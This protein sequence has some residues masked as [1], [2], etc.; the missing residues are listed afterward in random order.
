MLEGKIPESFL[1]KTRNDHFS[2]PVRVFLSSLFS[3]FFATES[4]NFSRLSFPI[5]KPLFIITHTW[6]CIIITHRIFCNIFWTFLPK[7]KLAFFA[8]WLQLRQSATGGWSRENSRHKIG[9]E[10]WREHDV[11]KVWASNNRNATSYRRLRFDETSFFCVF[12]HWKIESPRNT[13]SSLARRKDETIFLFPIKCLFSFSDVLR[14][15]L[16]S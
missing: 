10:R 1:H 5:I 3:S 12:R 6:L 13:F 2:P 4:A 16:F 11:K 8:G 15:K 9:S 14:P 7:A